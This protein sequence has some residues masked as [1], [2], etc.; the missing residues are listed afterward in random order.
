MPAWSS[1]PPSG[2]V[3]SGHLIG[4]LEA[5]GAEAIAERDAEPGS[6]SSEELL[7]DASFDF[8]AD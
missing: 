2:I 7:E 8:G 4:A 6:D 5:G 3:G 1:T